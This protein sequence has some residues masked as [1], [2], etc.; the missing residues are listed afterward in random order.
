MKD[1]SV[2]LK[3]ISPIFGCK[4]RRQPYNNHERPPTPTPRCARV[5]ACVSVRVRA[6]SRCVFVCVCVR[7]RACE[8]VCATI[9]NIPPSSPPHLSLSV[10]LPH[11][12]SLSVPLSPPSPTLSLSSYIDNERKI[13]L[14][15]VLVLRCAVVVYTLEAIQETRRYTSCLNTSGNSRF[16]CDRQ[17]ISVVTKRLKERKKERKGMTY[18]A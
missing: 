16:G 9:I 13:R 3:G 6:Y 15:W 12:L 8:R 17:V 18:N 4:G 10:S 11:S 7:A 2:S 5:H 14:S 1:T